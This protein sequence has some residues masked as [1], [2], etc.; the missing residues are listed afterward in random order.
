VDSKGYEVYDIRIRDTQTGLDLPDVIPNSCGK[1][2]CS[3]LMAICLAI[4]SFMSGRVQK[5]CYTWPIELSSVT[6]IR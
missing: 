6:I 5:S 2:M 1:D 4:C 3:V